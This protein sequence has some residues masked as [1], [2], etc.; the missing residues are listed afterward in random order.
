MKEGIT[1]NF[2]MS[3]VMTVTGTEK[4]DPKWQ[5]KMTT[6][7][8]AMWRELQTIAIEDEVKKIGIPVLMIAGAKDIMVPFTLMEKG[9]E[10]LA[11]EKEYFILENSNHMM[12]IDEP[13]L[14]LSKVIEFFQ[15]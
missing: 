5:K 7:V 2:E 14:F 6:I 11:G 12:F 8:N 1:K 10:T 4:I 13:D 9:Y 3:K 15:K